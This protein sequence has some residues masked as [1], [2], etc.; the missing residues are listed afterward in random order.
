MC[1]KSALEVMICM[2]PQFKS[3]FVSDF[4]NGF[5]AGLLIKH[6][7]SFQLKLFLR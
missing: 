2:G 4:V 1:N 5:G 6:H 7:L 3:D